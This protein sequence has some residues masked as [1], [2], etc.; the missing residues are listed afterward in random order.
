MSVTIKIYERKKELIGD[1]L[2]LDSSKKDIIVSS[3]GLR[4]IEDDEK[5]VL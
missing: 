2:L 1:I 3:K 5:A 4:R